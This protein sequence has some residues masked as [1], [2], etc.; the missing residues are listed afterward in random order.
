MLYRILTVIP[1]YINHT[2]SNMGL[3]LASLK[4]LKS[5]NQLD[6]SVICFLLQ[7]WWGQDVSSRLVQPAGLQPS[8]VKT[9]MYD[10]PIPGCT[11][12]THHKHILGL[13]NH[14][15]MTSLPQLCMQLPLVPF[16]WARGHPAT[17]VQTSFYWIFYWNGHSSSKG[18]SR[19]PH[20][21]LPRTFWERR[22]AVM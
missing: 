9:R 17:Q 22:W 18:L 13:G 16:H 15:S 12:I 5:S 21:R 2:H 11:F 19:H 6:E 4:L 8:T 7:E 20:L 14:H 10:E 3:I 1:H